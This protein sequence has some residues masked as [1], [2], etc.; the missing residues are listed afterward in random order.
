MGYTDQGRLHGFQETGD[1]RQKRLLS[2]DLYEDTLLSPAELAVEDPLPWLK[3]E[4]ALRDGDDDLAAHD[5]P[6]EMSVGLVHS[7]IVKIP[8]TG[9]WGASFSSQTPRSW[10]RPRSSSLMTEAV[11][12]IALC[13]DI[14]LTGGAKF[15]TMYYS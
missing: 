8:A 7:D 5:R 9:S 11:M 3:V 13:P 12:C 14:P 2:D 4:S 10:C 15:V 6:L 1:R